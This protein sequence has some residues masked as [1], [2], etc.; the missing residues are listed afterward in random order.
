M[1]KII[2][3]PAAR[4]WIYGVLVAAAAVAIGYGLI[5]AEQGNLWL[6]LAGAVLGLSNSLALA[7]TPKG[8]HS[9]DDS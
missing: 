1:N 8:K 6:A 5:T 2:P 7:N 3:S 4:A 9:A